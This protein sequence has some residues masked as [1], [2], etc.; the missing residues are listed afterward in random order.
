VSD[1]TTYDFTCLECGEHFE[2]ELADAPERGKVPCPACRSAL[3]RQ[4]F[5]S[6]LRH[7]LAGPGPD[8]TE[9]RDRKFG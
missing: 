8:I 1:R 3:V 6:Y 7:G 4:T 2:V 9:L 5:A